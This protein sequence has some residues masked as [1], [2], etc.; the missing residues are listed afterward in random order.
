M[1]NE[2]AITKPTIETILEHMSAMEARLSAKFDEQ[3]TALSKRVETLSERVDT[4][5]E[6]LGIRLDRIESVANTT[7]GEMLDLRA[8][9]REMRKQLREHF[10]TVH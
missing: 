10:S 8:D 9:F 5:E 6:R 2:D 3:F 4:L 7:R 1:S